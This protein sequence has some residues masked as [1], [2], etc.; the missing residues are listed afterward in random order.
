VPSATSARLKHKHPH[1]RQ[2]APKPAN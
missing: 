1:K 2:H